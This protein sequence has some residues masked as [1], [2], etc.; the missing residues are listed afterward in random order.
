LDPEVKK[1]VLRFFTYGLYGVTTHGEGLVNGMTANWLAQSS[2]EP[3]M[4]MVAVENDSLTLRL[5]R[6]NGH[7]AVNAYGA[8]HRELS[9]QLGRKSSKMPNKMEGIAW[10][11]SSRGNPILDEALGYLECEVRGE[12]P[13]GDHTVVVAEIV[14]AGLQRQAEPLIMKATGFRYFG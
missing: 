2:F 12:L 9:G 11:P 8:E 3:P 13:S 6:A 14:D 1:T 4:I 5:I 10:H 7:F